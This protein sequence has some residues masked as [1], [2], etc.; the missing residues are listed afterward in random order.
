MYY[1]SGNYEAFSKPEYPKAGNRKRAYIIGSGMAALSAACF[2]IRDGGMPGERIHI[3]EK[4]PIPGGALDGYRFESI[5]YVSRGERQFDTH[6]ECLWDLLRSIPSEDNPELSVL[7]EFYRLNKRDPN[8]SL[9]RVTVNHGEEARTEGKFGL[10]DMGAREIMHLFFMPDE[11]L[12]NKKIS[13][14]FDSEVFSSNFWMYVRSVF[15]F[16]NWHSALEMKRYIRRYLHYVDGLPDG[17][18]MRFTRYNQYEAI[19]LPVMR[20]LEKHG[21]QF[22]Y[23]VRVTNVVFDCGTARKFANRIDIVREGQEDSIDLTA[24]DLVFITNGS[25]V[26]NTGMGSQNDPAA[27]NPEIRE[28]SSFDMWRKIAVQNDAFGNPDA[29]CR[30]PEHTTWVTATITT[31][32]KAIVPYLKKVTKRDPFSGKTVSG[33][34]VTVKDSSWLLSWSVARQPV[35]SDQE[36]KQVVIWVV[37]LHTDQPGDY[38]GKTMKDCSGMEICEEWLYHLGVPED[39]IRDLA[40][41]HA[42]AVPV[43]MPYV[44]S[45]MMPRGAGDRPRVVPEGAVNFAF[46]GQFAETERDIVFTTEYSVRTGMEAV[47]TLLDI[48]RGVP[49]AWSGEYDLR[50]LM[51][52]AVK[53][54]D[55][56]TVLEMKMGRGRKFFLKRVL[57]KLRRTDL[58]K[59]LKEYHVI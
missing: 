30:N 16:E 55:G 9:C 48:D 36:N 27:Y 50:C 39:Q 43:V 58:Y 52:A 25:I 28:G 56:R 34:I 19:V 3:L 14:V 4:N 12:Q 18:C 47:Y 46:I 40:E 1:S 23:G 35:F 2:L 49:E 26:E 31:L 24:E 57:R 15:G 44:S 17:K 8:Y 7:D 22:D 29:F 10:S 59:M 5:G 20:Y 42:A 38:I 21:V 33:G 11:E 6:F 32:D 13:D 51:D 53:L 41:N 54:L 45:A 37:G